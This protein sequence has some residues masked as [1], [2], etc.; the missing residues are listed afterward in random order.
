MTGSAAA[1]RGKSELFS[2][3]VGLLAAGDFDLAP[4][5][6][7]EFKFVIG[8]REDERTNLGASPISISPAQR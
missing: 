6:A 1:R 7:L 2:A 5:C 3:P 4:F 8:V